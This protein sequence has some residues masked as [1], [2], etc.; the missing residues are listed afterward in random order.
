[1]TAIGSRFTSSRTGR[2]QRSTRVIADP[3]DRFHDT[4]SYG[5]PGSGAA[6]RGA[7]IDLLIDLNGYS[8][9]SRLPLFALRPAPVQVAWFNMFATSGLE[10]S[11]TWWATSM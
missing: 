5:Q 9:P 11:T 3:R 8:R 7:Q 4:S 2:N 6:H 1:M 10:A